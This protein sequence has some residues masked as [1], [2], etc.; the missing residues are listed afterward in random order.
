MDDSPKKISK[1]VTLDP[2]V[3]VE[4]VNPE[5]KKEEETEEDRKKKQQEE[6]VEKY[7]EEGIFGRLFSY[8][9]D[10][11]CL[12]FLGVLIAMGN[13]LIFPTFSIFI[14]RM[15]ATLLKLSYSSTQA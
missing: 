5:E 14:S 15:F 7:E 3:E 9:S 8:A 2:L 11:K 13:G 6:L 10:K 4:I 1:K 12:F